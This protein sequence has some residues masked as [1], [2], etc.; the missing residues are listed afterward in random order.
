MIN[1][2]VAALCRWIL[3]WFVRWFADDTF[4]LCRTRG[5]KPGGRDSV[6][7]HLSLFVPGRRGG[8]GR[9]GGVGGL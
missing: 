7:G 6:V 9:G 8:R 1:R 3:R 2:L 5:R 4:S